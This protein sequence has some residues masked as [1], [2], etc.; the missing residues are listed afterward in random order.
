MYS[1]DD[2]DDD[3]DDDGDDNVTAIFKQYEQAFG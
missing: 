1:Y 3:D 2:D